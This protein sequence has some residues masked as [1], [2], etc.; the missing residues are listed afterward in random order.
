VAFV[1][2]VQ[3]NHSK[4][5]AHLKLRSIFPADAVLDTV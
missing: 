3:C 2:N 4:H 1:D 5:M